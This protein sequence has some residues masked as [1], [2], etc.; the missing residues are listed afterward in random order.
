MAL[1]QI[2]Y[3]YVPEELIERPKHGFNPVGEWLEDR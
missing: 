1:R 2:L 3:K